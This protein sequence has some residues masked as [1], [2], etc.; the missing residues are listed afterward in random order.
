MPVYGAPPSPSRLSPTEAADIT[1]PSCID[2]LI[3]LPGADGPEHTAC[4]GP[5][6]TRQAA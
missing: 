2:G 1:P 3:T 5:C 6:C 4:L